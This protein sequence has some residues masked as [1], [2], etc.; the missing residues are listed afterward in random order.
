MQ[1]IIKS[2]NYILDTQVKKI[3]M[4]YFSATSFLSLVATLDKKKHNK[5]HS[6]VSFLMATGWNTPYQN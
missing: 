4:C 3:V 6:V 5:E 2:D 1:R